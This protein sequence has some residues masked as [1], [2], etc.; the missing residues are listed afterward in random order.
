MT[1]IHTKALYTQRCTL[2][3]Y[4]R[5][6]ES[7]ETLRKAGEQWDLTALFQTHVVTHLLFVLNFLHE[8]FAFPFSL[9][10]AVIT[11]SY[12]YDGNRPV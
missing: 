3:H 7:L 2:Q 4:V 12:P 9:E 1:L 5:I 10:D 8:Y 11:M 6:G